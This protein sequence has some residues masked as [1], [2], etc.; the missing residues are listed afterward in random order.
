[1]KTT[2]QAFKLHPVYRLQSDAVKMCVRELLRNVSGL[3]F[4]R[5]HKSTGRVGGCGVR[6]PVKSVLMGIMRGHIANPAERAQS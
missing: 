3:K 6:R 5:L 4:D 1:M 2:V